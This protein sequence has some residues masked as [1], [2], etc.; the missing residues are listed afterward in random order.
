MEIP[1]DGENNIRSLLHGLVQELGRVFADDPGNGADAAVG[2][3]DA[4][5]TVFAD[6]VAA[7]I[8]PA[9]HAGRVASDEHVEETAVILCLELL[10]LRVG[11]EVGAGP[12][13]FAEFHPFNY[14]VRIGVAGVDGGKHALAHAVPVIGERIAFGG[15]II[16]SG[17]SG[18]V[19]IAVNAGVHQ[20]DGGGI[21]GT[22]TDDVIGIKGTDVITGGDMRSSNSVVDAGPVGG[23]QLIIGAVLPEHIVGKANDL[24]FF[25]SWQGVTQQFFG[26]FV[27]AVTV[28]KEETPVIV[29]ILPAVSVAVAGFIGT[30]IPLPGNVVAYHVI[31]LGQTPLFDHG[32]DFVPGEVKGVGMGS[33]GQIHIKAVMLAPTHQMQDIVGV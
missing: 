28:Q 12:D 31:Q 21:A 27:G 9:E 8:P 30:D 24:A 10:V 3:H 18:I 1:V 26:V 19:V 7:E 29:K 32:F 14:V 33:E 16:K 15:T 4:E 20:G 2:V 22:G 11:G 5:V 6:A 17:G 25:V 13:G 23:Y